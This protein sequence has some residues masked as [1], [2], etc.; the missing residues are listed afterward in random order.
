MTD[1][2]RHIRWGRRGRVL[3]LTLDRPHALNAADEALHEELSRVFQDADRDPESDVIVLT[4]AGSAFCAGG[5]VEWM[6]RA[7][8]QPALFERTCY[9]AKRIIF[10]MLDCDKPMIGH[11]NGH[12]MG[13]GCTLALFCDVTFM[14]ATAKIGDPHVLMGVAAGDGGTIIWPQ[15]IGL[16]R[17]KEYLLTGDAIPATRAGEWGLVNHVLPPEELGAAVDAF[18]DRLASGALKAVRWTKVAINAPLKQIVH[19]AMDTAIAYELVTN[20]SRDHQEAVNAFREKRPAVFT[21]N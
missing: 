17:A 10:S 1:G 6:Q 16:A 8:D 2:Y 20:S 5:D 4:G 14:S 15:L 13:F 9:E 12:A 19:G 21:G 11:I 7:I 3:T 18:A